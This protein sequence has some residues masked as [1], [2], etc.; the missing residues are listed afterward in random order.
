MIQPD[1]VDL[2]QFY[3]TSLGRAAQRHLRRAIH[4]FWP[5]VAG[6]S[7]LGVG[8][9]I[10]YLGGFGDAV[11]PVI[12]AMPPQQGVTFWPEAGPGRGTLA[13]M[14]ELPFADCSFDRI[15]MVHGLEALEQRRTVLRELWRVLAPTGRIIVAVPNRRGVWARTER[16]P[17][18]HGIPFSASQLTEIMRDHLFVPE[19]STRCLYFPPVDSPLVLAAA[20]AWE[21]IGSQW[22]SVFGGVSVVEASKQVYALPTDRMAADRRH[23]LRLPSWSPIPLPQSSS[24]EGRLPPSP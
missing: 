3:E 9:P 13:E 10:P 24:I 5:S 12:V 8:Y 1:I 16:T 7:V 23:R 14:D 22:F 4:K 18:G 19:R 2:R 20:S 17:F 11:P 6:L 21:K 15:V